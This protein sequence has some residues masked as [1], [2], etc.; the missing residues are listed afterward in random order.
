L[1]VK[2]GAKR[3]KL[4]LEMSLESAFEEIKATA[5]GSDRAMRIEINLS[6]EK[7]CT[8]NITQFYSK[9]NDL[10]TLLVTNKTE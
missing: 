10:K 3:G 2:N 7:K 5:T 8:F 4:R 6:R 1:G 9:E